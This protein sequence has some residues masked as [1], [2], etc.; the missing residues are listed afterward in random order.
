M[1]IFNGRGQVLVE[2]SGRIVFHR[3]AV[4]TFDIADVEFM[5][6]FY[7]VP[8]QRL[9]LRPV[10]TSQGGCRL[11]KKKAGAWITE[12]QDFLKDLHLTGSSNRRCDARWD[13][14]SEAIIVRISQMAS[15]ARHIRGRQR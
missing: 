2:P 13:R 5:S 9:V 15:A 1:S 3:K 6:M 12:G 7:S 14:K 8:A 4:A 11:A 10:R